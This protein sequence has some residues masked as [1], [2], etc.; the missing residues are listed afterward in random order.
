MSL[1][2][3]EKLRRPLVHFLAE[4]SISEEDLTKCINNYE[5]SNIQC[6]Y[7]QIGIGNDY[8]ISL[9]AIAGIHKS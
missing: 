8:A 3:Y 1:K 6:S 5:N 2:Q 7:L 9:G 4:N